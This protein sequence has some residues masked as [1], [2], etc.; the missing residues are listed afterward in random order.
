LT[1]L[2]VAEHDEQPLLFCCENDHG[3]VM[4][5]KERLAGHVRVIDCMVDRVCTGR[6]ISSMGVDVATEPWC[7]SIVVLEPNLTERLPFHSSVATA[8]STA[9]EADY[10]SERKFTLVNGM[11]TTLAF[12]TLRELFTDDD[13][14][15]EYIL[16]KYA[17]VPREQQRMMEA[18]RTA[19]VAQLIDKFGIDSLMTWHACESREEAW[20]VVLDHA[21][22][23]LEERFS[24]TDD[25]V[26]RVLGG[27]V[28]N[29]WVTRLRPTKSWMADYL[30]SGEPTMP[31]HLVDFFR[32]AIERD[33]VRALE[34]GCSV[35]DAEWRG[36]EVEDEIMSGSSAVQLVASYVEELIVSSRRFCS[37]E[38]EI[39]HKELIKEQRQAGGKA[40]APKVKAAAVSQ[41]GRGI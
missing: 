15:R 5:L 40:N 41:R 30:E 37:R 29:R 16:L 21:D 39:T 12:M 18:W 13:G 4:K 8:P 35:E 27:G 34:R 6:T 31:A 9:A 26:S 22:H 10:L 33:R 23:V 3:S 11:H 14:G 17:K 19:R 38:R 25:V 24:K 36:C 32:Y 20:E 7:G 1:S 28:S 2:P